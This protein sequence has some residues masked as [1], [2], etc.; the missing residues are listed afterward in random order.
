MRPI[1]TLMTDFGT[2]D[3]YVAEMKGVLL[4]TV[5]D[6]P[7][8]DVTHEIPPQD[9]AAARVLLDRYWR[10]FPVGTVH[11]V[12]VDPGVGTGR[13]AL[14]VESERRVLLGPDN[15]VLSAALRV[16][17]ART[18]ALHVPSGASPTFHG[19]DVFAPA[20]AALAAGAPIAQLGRPHGSPVIEPAAEPRTDP[21]GWLVGEVVAIDRFGNVITSIEPREPLGVAEHR[22]VRIAVRRTYADVD[23][24]AALGLVG[25]SGRLEIAIRNGNAAHALGARRGD[26]VRYSDRA[27][28]AEQRVTANRLP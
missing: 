10:R 14:A 21:D 8:V 6:A 24:G 2:A 5:P 12:V 23:Q 9:V 16:P 18:Y 15:G 26:V 20:A 3:S 7:I 13:A 28:P 4:A 19:R 27:L 17:G 11:V 25:S 1:V 22:G